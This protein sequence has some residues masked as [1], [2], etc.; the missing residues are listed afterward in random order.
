MAVRTKDRIKDGPA[1]GR[2]ASPAAAVPIVAKIPAP[3]I[4]PTPK[5]VTSTG[6]RA[7]FKRCWDCSVSATR[8]SIAF[9]RRRSFSISSLGALAEDDHVTIGIGY[10]E[11]WA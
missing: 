11:F 2:V 4:A 9:L 6:P 7:F 8:S 10:F 5:A 3:M 1:P